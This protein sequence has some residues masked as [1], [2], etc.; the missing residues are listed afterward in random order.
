MNR[1]FVIALVGAVALALSAGG[2]AFA[3]SAGPAV[4]VEIKTQTKTLRNVV[5]HG[6]TG[7]ITKGGTPKGKCS[8]NSAAGA[9]GAATHGK[10]TATYNSTYGAFVDSILGVKPKSNYYWE[11]FVNGNSSNVGICG[12]KLKAHETILFKIAK[13]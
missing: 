10:W 5:V 2:A 9:L 11:L 1:K 13:G 6:Q 4:R 8:A 3:A 7:W 12:V